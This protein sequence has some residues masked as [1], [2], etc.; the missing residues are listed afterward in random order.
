M[1]GDQGL[2]KVEIKVGQTHPHMLL[3]GWAD[4]RMGGWGDGEM[5]R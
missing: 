1:L 2:R 5:G 3:G 4:G